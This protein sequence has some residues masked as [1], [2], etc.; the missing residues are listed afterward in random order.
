MAA[1]HAARHRLRQYAVQR[2]G[3]QTDSR[4]VRG[5]ASGTGT[6]PVDVTVGEGLDLGPPGVTGGEGRTV[7]V[8][9]VVLATGG[10]FVGLGAVVV[11]AVVAGVTAGGTWLVVTGGAPAGTAPG[12]VAP[13]A[14]GTVAGGR[15]GPDEA[16]FVGVLVPEPQEVRGPAGEVLAT[17]GPSV[18]GTSKLPLPPATTLRTATAVRAPPATP[19]A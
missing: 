4:A 19:I 18:V 8:G 9:V 2:L 6:Q 12:A 17:L 16:P 13:G 7:G 5:G 11:G 10:L 15:T 14:Q 3:P 1:P